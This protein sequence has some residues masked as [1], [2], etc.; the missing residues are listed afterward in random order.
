MA[1]ILVIGGTRFFGKRLVSLLLQDPTNQITLLNRGTT[2][3]PFGERVT[4]IALDRKELSR[5]HVSQS[6]DVVY[7][8]VCFEPEEAQA[9]CDVFS[10]RV[11]HYVFTSSQSVYGAGSSIPES[12]FDPSAHKNRYAPEQ[13]RDYAESK[14]QAEAVFFQNADFPVTAVRFPIVLGEDDYTGR[15]RFHVDRVSQQQPIFFPQLDAK[16]SLISSEDA[17]AFLGSLIQKKAA[18]PINCCSPQPIALR[19]FIAL[20]EAATGKSARLAPTVEAGEHSPLGAGAHWYMDTQK[21]ESFGFFPKKVN[22]WLP[23]ALQKMI[24]D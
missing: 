8:Q 21:L 20:I 11:G 17:A 15:L 5:A 16:I 19:D 24:V 9:A 1:K 13:K 18:G 7:D 12:A 2:P 10:K 22:D 14:R 23:K 6:W 3:D 4:R